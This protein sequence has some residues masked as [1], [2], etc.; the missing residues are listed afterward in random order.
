M[1]GRRERTGFANA[2]FGVRPAAQDARNET[3]A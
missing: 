2:A 1:S 3:G